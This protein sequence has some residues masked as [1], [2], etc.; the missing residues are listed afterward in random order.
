MSYIF[1]LCT[2]LSIIHYHMIAAGYL[3]IVQLPATLTI[4]ICIV[5]APLSHVISCY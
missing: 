2:Y 3:I 5:I 4:L 1:A